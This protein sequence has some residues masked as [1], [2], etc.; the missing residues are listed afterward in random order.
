MKGTHT[1]ALVSFE[2]AKTLTGHVVLRRTSNDANEEVIV[3]SHG[4]MRCYFGRLK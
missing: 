1:G 2:P 3:V 4:S